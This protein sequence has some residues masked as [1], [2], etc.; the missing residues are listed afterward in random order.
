MVLK[1]TVGSLLFRV[2]GYSQTSPKRAGVFIEKVFSVKTGPLEPMDER[3][4]Q[5]LPLEF[6]HFV[7]R[8]SVK[9]AVKGIRY[10]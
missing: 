1:K 2:N 3:K 5:N 8:E 4:F 9:R 7:E 10:F 6:Y